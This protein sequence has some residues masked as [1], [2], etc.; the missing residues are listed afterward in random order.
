MEPTL[1]KPKQLRVE[2]KRVTSRSETEE[3]NFVKSK[4]DMQLPRR[5]KLL[6][7]NDDPT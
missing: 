2:P 5:A 3:P 4:T 6:M 1:L 7:D